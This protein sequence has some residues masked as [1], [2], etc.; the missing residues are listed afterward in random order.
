VVSKIAWYGFFLA[1]LGE[2]VLRLLHRA[3]PTIPT[4]SV[5]LDAFMLVCAAVYVV[6]ESLRWW[7]RSMFD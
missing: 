3:T 4:M 1:F 5:Y 7:R 2:A 6:T